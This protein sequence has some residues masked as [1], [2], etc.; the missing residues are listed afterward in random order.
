MNRLEPNRNY[1]I[2]SAHDTTVAN[3]LNTLGVFKPMGY[4]NPPFAATVLFELRKFSDGFKVQVFYKNSTAEPQPLH[5]PGCGTSCTLDKMFEVYKAVLPVNWQQE[6]ELSLLQMPL[7]VSVDDSISLTMIF[8]F[9][10][11]MLMAGFIVLFFATVY[12]RRDY[13]SED[14]WNTLEG[15]N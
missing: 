8:A 7:A 10:A 15:W 11:L 14:R 12:K 5:L 6:C 4:H 1:W 9:F 3:M 13:I 2:Y